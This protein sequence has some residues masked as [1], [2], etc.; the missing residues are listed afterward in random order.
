MQPHPNFLPRTAGR[1]VCVE[2][3]LKLNT[4]GKKD[5]YAALWVDGVLDTE[6]RE[7]DFRDTYEAHTINAVLLEAYWNEGS[8]VDQY[9]WYDDFVVSTKPIGPVTAATAPQL[10]L[11]TTSPCDVEIAADSRGERV[12]WKSRPGEAKEGK[13]TASSKLEPGTIHFCRI[14]RSGGAWSPWHQPFI[15]GK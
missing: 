12:V 9:R 6:R 10:L 2:A 11:T 13:V 5:G 7:M 3:R 14:R 15:A 8:P 1:W 4:P